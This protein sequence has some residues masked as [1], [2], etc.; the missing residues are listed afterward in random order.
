[1][2]QFFSCD[3]FLLGTLI[4]FVVA[5]FPFLPRSVV[6][7]L[8]SVSDVTSQALS[9]LARISNAIIYSAI[10]IGH[11]EVGV[12]HVTLRHKISSTVIGYRHISFICEFL[13]L[14]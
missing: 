10:I 1:M 5:I 13:I 2:T 7:L 14:L 8:A 11:P 12:P 3:C 9:F 6:L 4:I